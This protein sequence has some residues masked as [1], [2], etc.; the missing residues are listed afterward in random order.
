MK[1]GTSRITIDGQRVPTLYR[2]Q[3]V[4]RAT[5]SAKAHEAEQK[6]TETSPITGAQIS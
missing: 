4:A 1:T 5:Q 6:T 3:E 2:A